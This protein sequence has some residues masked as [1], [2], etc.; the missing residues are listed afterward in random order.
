MFFFEKEQ[1]WKKYRKELGIDRAIN[2]LKEKGF[3]ANW[4]EQVPD[5]KEFGCIYVP[6]GKPY[7]PSKCPEYEGYYLHGGGGGVKCRAA[8][9]IIPGI[10]WDTVCR[11]NYAQCPFY[12]EVH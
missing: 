1:S 2:Y 12:K 10:A 11:N 9:E 7:N 6:G 5:S 8:A 4:P 3:P